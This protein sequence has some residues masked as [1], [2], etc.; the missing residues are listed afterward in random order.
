M[1][2]NWTTQDLVALRFH[3]L[4]KKRAEISLLALLLVK[5]FSCQVHAN[6]GIVTDGSVGFGQFHGTSS[7]LLP[8]QTNTVTITP[9]MGTT[10]TS[11]SHANAFYSFKT[12]NIDN[13]QTVTFTEPKFVDNVIARVTGKDVSQIDGKLS[14]TQESGHANFYL[15]NPNGVLFGNGASIDVPGDFHVTTAHF[16]KFQDGAKYGADP[17]HSHLTTAAP[18]SFGFTASN[19]SN[20]VLIDVTDGAQLKNPATPN[21]AIDLVAQNI[22]IENS[23]T[24][25]ANDVRL[26][27]AKGNTSVSLSHDVYGNLALPKFAP[28]AANAGKVQIIGG[29]PANNSPTTTVTSSSDGGG[30]IAI[31]GGGVK[32]SNGGFI[33]SVQTGATAPS[34]SNG[35]TIKASSLRMENGGTIQTE[36]RAS[37]D[38]SEVSIHSSGNVEI[39][40]GSSIKTLSGR[41][42]SGGGVSIKSNNTV[43]LN[44]KNAPN[45]CLDVDCT[46]ISA[47]STQIFVSNSNLSITS[48]SILL[49]YGSRLGGSGL[50]IDLSTAGGISLRGESSIEDN[51]DLMSGGVISIIAESLYLGSLSNVRSVSGTNPS[52]NIWTQDGILLA[53]GSYINAFTTSGHGGSVNIY[54]RGGILLLGDSTAESNISTLN[55]TRHDQTKSEVKGPLAQ[56]PDGGR[57]AIDSTYTYIDKGFI[58]VGT[59]DTGGSINL[60]PNLF[61]MGNILNNKLFVSDGNIPPYTKGDTGGYNKGNNIVIENGQGD[62]TNVSISGSLLNISGDM[63]NL[64]PANFKSKEIANSCDVIDKGSLMSG[65]KGGKGLNAMDR[66]IF[67]E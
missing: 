4:N 7:T 31:W 56:K 63:A 12:F 46:V 9:E 66:M 41:G 13:G 33:D 47:E 54:D 18:A 23:A 21:K 15:L 1:I 6:G 36:S 32:V 39:L 60:G 37:G 55:L 24:V 67:G 57:V 14:V 64:P 43:V 3:S 20:N 62:T 22:K 40:S 34:V 44:G 42:L 52:V 58:A 65:G 51:S 8:D 49:D 25:S 45:A 38:G 28:T 19:H 26:V 59:S 16:I 17:V 48:R 27:A 61:V 10:S 5:G 30:R 2:A 35:I 29:D 53:G 11:N 50:R